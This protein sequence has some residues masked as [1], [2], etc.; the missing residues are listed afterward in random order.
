MKTGK[1]NKIILRKYLVK[2]CYFILYGTWYISTYLDI[3]YNVRTNKT[4][5]QYIKNHITIDSKYMLIRYHNALKK[6][7][8]WYK[9]HV[10][11]AK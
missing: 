4:R 3:Y 6:V 1:I 9:I 10:I 7:M 8:I 11:S 2:D 5:W